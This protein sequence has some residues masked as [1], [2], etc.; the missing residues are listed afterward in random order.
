MPFEDGKID[1]RSDTVT[2]PTPE[3][4]KAMYEAEVGDDYYRDDPTVNKMQEMAADIFNRE[5][6]LLV[7]SGTMGNSICVF[8]QTH[9]GQEIILES[10]A[11][12]WRCEAAHLATISGVT[13]YL[14]Q[15]K[16]GVIVPDELDVHIRGKEIYEPRTSLIALETPNNG[17]GG[18]VPPPENIE[19]VSEFAQ[20]RGLAFHID[21]AR[22]FNATVKLGVDPA[23]YVSSANSII[24]CLSKSLCCPFGSIILGSTDFIEEARRCRLTFGGTLRQAGI[25]AAAGIVA[26]DRMIDRLEEDH[27]VARK[28]A[29]ELLENGLAE[30]DINLVQTNMLR[31]DFSPICS[32][33]FD[34]RD[35]MAREG[36]MMSITEDAFSR[37]VTHYWI[38]MDDVAKVIETLQSYAKKS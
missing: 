23:R 7:S 36:I 26:L 6:A 22:I 21:G 28:L 29:E 5:A 4:R 2:R 34:L 20:K 13:V 30:L 32:N 15:G 16:D 12:M 14:V 38:S 8:T 17:A 19:A 9:T 25:M 18:T 31:V 1:L 11:H 27:L 33:G 35:F 37:L 24:F 10:Q 3:M